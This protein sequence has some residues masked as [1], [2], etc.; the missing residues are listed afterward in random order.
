MYIASNG[1]II[2][3]AKAFS[4]TLSIP[5]TIIQS[6]INMR[7]LLLGFAAMTYLLQLA[8]AAPVEKS[9]T[10]CLSEYP[11]GQE[12]YEKPPWWDPL[13]LPLDELRELAPFDFSP[14]GASP[15]LS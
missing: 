3:A 11:S 1:N 15:R 8:E 9:P 12:V 5:T 2:Y 7:L 10:H 4:V 6:S 14:G 13:H